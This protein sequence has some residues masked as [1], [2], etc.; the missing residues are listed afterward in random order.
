M[1]WNPPSNSESNDIHGHIARGDGCVD[2]WRAL[3]LSGEPEVP[4]IEGLFLPDGPRQPMSLP[5]Y[6]DVVVHMRDYRNRYQDYWMSTASETKTGQPVEAFISP[7]AP[8][9]GLLPNRFYHAEYSCSAN[10]LDLPTVV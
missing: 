8:T 1:E 10:V 7:V 2:V 4:E 5:E 6:Q 3:Q 9:A